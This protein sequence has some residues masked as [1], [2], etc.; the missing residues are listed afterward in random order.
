MKMYFYDNMLKPKNNLLYY[1]NQEA[2]GELIWHLAC[3]IRGMDKYVAI[4]E[5]KDKSAI[6]SFL[7]F[8]IVMLAHHH[9]MGSTKL[10]HAV[11]PYFDSHGVLNRLIHGLIPRFSSSCESIWRMRVSARS[12]RS[13]ALAA[14]T[15]AALSS[16]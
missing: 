6:S 2:W 15:A 10:G 5:T 13:N 12:F 7:E 9:T 11:G 16:K 14:R 8:P 4:R 1:Q 3:T